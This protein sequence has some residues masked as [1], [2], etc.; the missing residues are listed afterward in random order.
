[1]SDVII[2]RVVIGHPQGTSEMSLEV[3][4]VSPHSTEV[5]GL[6]GGRA[7]RARFSFRIEDLGDVAEKGC[8]SGRVHVAEG[9][10]SEA[11]E[12]ALK[13]GCRALLAGQSDL[14]GEA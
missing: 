12:D 4:V 5:H 7:V 1:V 14:G 11:D 3:R 10:I 9:A 6:S 2:R 8:R 13:L